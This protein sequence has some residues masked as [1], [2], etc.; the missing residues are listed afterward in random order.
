MTDSD[1]LAVLRY[2]YRDGTIQ[3]V[4]PMRVVSDDAVLVTWLA[5][6][7]SIMYWA[8]KDGAD[9]RTLPLVDRFHQHLT[10]APRS[11]QGGGVLRVMPTGQPFQVLHFWEDDG[12]FAGWYVNFESV[13]RRRGIWIDT[14]DWHL[15]LWLD[16]DGTP[17]WKDEE[18]A[19][20]AVAAGHLDPAA[21]DTARRTGLE[22]IADF[23]GW[24]RTVGDWRDFTPPRHWRTPL[25][26]P[27]DWGA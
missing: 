15:D 26:L 10:T 6:G 4:F 2:R 12:A 13:R 7:T 17:T 25:E 11:W 16:P 27:E 14:M 18:E 1:E 23:D 9:P 22:I 21:L 24:L 20:F 19:A 5:P 3:A 8:L